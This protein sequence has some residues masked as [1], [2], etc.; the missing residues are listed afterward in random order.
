MHF[1]YHRGAPIIPEYEMDKKIAYV[2]NLPDD[3]SIKEVTEKLGVE[4][5]KQIK[6]EYCRLGLPAHAKVYFNTDEAVNNLV[7]NNK[8]Y[9]EVG[10]RLCFIKTHFDKEKL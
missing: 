3:F 10:S 8:T 5:V 1:S 7:L 6:V 9:I 2:F 4:T